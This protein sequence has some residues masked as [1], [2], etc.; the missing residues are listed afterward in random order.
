M[1]KPQSRINFLS[2]DTDILK[3]R[4]GR[5]PSLLE[6][7]G[8]LVSIL[9]LGAFA[10]LYTLGYQPVDYTNYVLCTRGDLTHFYYAVWFQL[11]LVPFG[12]LPPLHGYILFSLLGLAG[13]FFAARLFSTDSGFALLT[14]QT[15]YNL[16]MG[17][18]M[19][20]LL[21][22]LALF[23]WGLAQKK[24]WLAGIGLVIAVTK[25]HT[26]FI[27]SLL[28]LLFAE[29]SWKDRLKTLFVPACVALVSLLIDP[30]WP[31]KL[32]ERIE[33]VPPSAEGNISLFAV[34]G[35]W[36]LLLLLPPLL[37]PLERS[38]RFLS[39]LAAVPLV[40]PYFQQADLLGVYVFPYGPIILLGNLGFSKFISWEAL[41]ISMQAVSIVLYI[42]SL[43]KPLLAARLIRKHTGQHP[44]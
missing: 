12:K 14:Y 13:T 22:G 35:I 10:K 26:G 31:L 42:F 34:T 8:L 43:L 21:G 38:D 19:G 25:P 3:K 17:T 23:W 5:K 28:L 37:L 15:F 41:R 16:F 27:L 39:L 6:A 33:A 9:F 30:Q 2:L 32:L 24:Y 18:Y 1:K 20:I 44:G 7:A 40:M 29:I 11:F 4:I 36:T